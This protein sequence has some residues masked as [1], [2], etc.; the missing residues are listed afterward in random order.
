MENLVGPYR[1][2]RLIDRGGQ[3]S[4]YLGYDQRLQRR[5]AIKIYRLPPTRAARKELRREAQLVAGIQS[6]KVVQIHDVIESGTH[7]AMVMEYVPGCSLAD[8]LAGA[9]PSI[10]SVLR[11]GADIAGALALARQNHVVHGDVKPGNVLITQ[12]GRAKLT[13]FGISRTTADSRSGRWAPGSM[14][15]LSPEQFLGQPLDERAD[16]FALGALLYQMVCGEQPFFSGGR[17]DPTRLLQHPP[18]PL[19]EMVSGDVELPEPLVAIIS[20]LLEKDPRRRP[21]NTRRVRQVMRTVLRTLPISLHNSLLCE[22]RPFFRHE[23]PDDI[24][25]QIPRDLGQ[26]GRSA[27]IP[28]GTRWAVFLH[29]LKSLRWPARTALA[30]SVFTMAAVPV[31][32]AL[33]NTVTPVQFNKLQTSFHGAGRFPGNISRDW[34]VERVR[35]AVA[36]Q[37]GPIRVIGKTGAYPVTVLYASGQPDNWNEAAAVTVDMALRCFESVCVFTVGREQAGERTSERGVL[38]AD[39]PVQEWREVV[40]DTTLALYR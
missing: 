1:I 17:L 14:S 26:Q 25:L 34:I 2:L 5:V 13:D 23:S 22:A 33:R 3:G 39:M 40:R 9:R 36:E 15:A 35:D 38:L 11:V 29:R 31:V 20:A 28:Q 10:A 27:L 21:R 8:F 19:V 16:L 24:P 30:V 7:L 18:R 4:V 6:P 32:I 12:G 37:L